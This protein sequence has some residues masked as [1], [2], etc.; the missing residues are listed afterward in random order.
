VLEFLDRILPGMDMEI[1]QEARKLLEKQGL[2]FR[3]S[4]RVSKAR[5]EGDQVVV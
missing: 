1:A 3:L 5:V 2:Q 4:T